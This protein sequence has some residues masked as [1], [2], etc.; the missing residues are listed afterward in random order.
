[1]DVDDDS[2]TE[3]ASSRPPKAKKVD[4]RKQR[5]MESKR[6]L[7]RLAKDQLGQKFILSQITHSIRNPAASIQFIY[8]GPNKHEYPS[9][10]LSTISAE[11]RNLIKRAIDRN[12]L[13][14]VLMEPSDDGTGSAKMRSVSPPTSS[15]SVILASATAAETEDFVTFKVPRRYIPSFEHDGDVADTGP[16]V[17]N[18]W[19]DE[20]IEE[21]RRQIVE[22]DK[23]II[24]LYQ[25]CGRLNFE[26]S[27]LRRK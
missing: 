21:Q 2:Q 14:A 8:K 15:T 19:Q 9:V 23:R 6:L 12:F 3:G 22:K 26:L 5:M 16:R 17:E 25:E 24:E 11:N 27:L 1:M 20:L 13:T 18:V 7:I 4:Q 10:S